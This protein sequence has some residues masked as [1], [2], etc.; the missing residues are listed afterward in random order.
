MKSS[1][2]YNTF[3]EIWKKFYLH[4]NLSCTIAGK[5]RRL[6]QAKEEAQDEIEKYRQE[7]EK[8]FR[9]F[10]AKV[11]IIIFLYAEIFVIKFSMTLLKPMT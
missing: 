8:Q 1:P 7:R 4:C 2:K 9:D 11:S 10:E 6:K 5:A 3:A